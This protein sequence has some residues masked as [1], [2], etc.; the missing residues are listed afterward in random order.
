M[1][2]KL[3]DFVV[4]DFVAIDRD[5]KAYDR[6]FKAFDRDL[7]HLTVISQ[8]PGFSHMF[9]C[10]CRTG[11]W[12]LAQWRLGSHNKTSAGPSKC[13]KPPLNLSLPF[14]LDQLQGQKQGQNLEQA[15]QKLYL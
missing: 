9:W 7:Q 5:F 1:V 14:G 10:F 15:R 6:D 2:L 12:P 13:V 8:S 4:R 11:Y 3:L